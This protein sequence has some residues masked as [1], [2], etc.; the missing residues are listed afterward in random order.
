MNLRKKIYELKLENARLGSAGASMQ[1]RID[2]L[3]RELNECQFE[4][5][6]ANYLLNRQERP[7]FASITKVSTDIIREI[8]RAEIDKVLSRIS[9]EIKSDLS[10]FVKIVGEE[11]RPTVTID[12]GAKYE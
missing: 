9:I 5:V 6:I 3:E 4:N 10:R 12:L 2:R 11:E 7:N 8:V 1:K